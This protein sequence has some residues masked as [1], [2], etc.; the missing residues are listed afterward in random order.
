MQPSNHVR[1]IRI[2]LAVFIAGPVFSGITAFPLQTELSWLDSILHSR[3]F[4]NAA[5][6]TRLLPWIECVSQALYDTN[7]HYPFLAC[8]TDWL[9]FAHLVIAVAT[10]WL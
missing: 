6:S 10:R 4:Y 7:A 2:W 1:R 8:G 3:S 9:A 5:Q